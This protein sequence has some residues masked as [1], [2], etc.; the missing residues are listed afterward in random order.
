VAL[1]VGGG[2]KSMTVKLEGNLYAALCTYCYQ[3][4]HATGTKLT[5]QQVIGEALKAFLPTPTG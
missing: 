3:R 2:V 4:E 5:H 1:R